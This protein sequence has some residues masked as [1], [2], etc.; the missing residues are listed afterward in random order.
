MFGQTKSISSTLFADILLSSCEWE[1]EDNRKS[2]ES[3]EHSFGVLGSAEGLNFGTFL[4][5]EQS[6]CSWLKNQTFLK[7]YSVVLRNFQPQNP[8][9]IKES[10][11]PNPFTNVLIKENMSVS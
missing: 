7:C 4:V 10:F 6:V 2:T 11:S 9:K 5:F 3:E 1:I 8:K